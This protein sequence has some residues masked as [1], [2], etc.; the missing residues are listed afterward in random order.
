MLKHLESICVYPASFSPQRNRSNMDER[1]KRLALE[2]RAFMSFRKE[3]S[4]PEEV[5]GDQGTVRNN[6]GQVLQLKLQ[7]RRTKEA[8]MSCGIMPPLKSSA[9]FPEQRRSLE[10]AKNEH[11]NKRKNRSG[12]ES[13]EAIRKHILD[14]KST[15]IPL[16]GKQ[17]QQR[18]VRHADE[19]SN[20]I[21]QRPG[22]MELI[23][24]NILPVNSYFKQ[25]ITER[26]FPHTSR[27][28]SSCDE[29]SNDS[30]S[31]R[32]SESRGH[33][34]AI[35]PACS[36]AEKMAGN[37]LSSPAKV[38]PS[39]L[40]FQLSAIPLNSSMQ[41][42]CGNTQAQQKLIP[43]HLT[44]KQKKTKDN[45]PKIKKL[46]YHQYIPPDKKGETETL[47][48]LDSSYAKILQQQQIFLQLQ[49]LSQQQHHTLLSTEPNR[50]QDPPPSSSS[51]LPSNSSSAQLSSAPSTVTSIQHIHSCPS[52]AYLGG[53]KVLSLHLDLDE[54]KVAE[55]K[56]ELKLRRLPVSGTRKDLIERLRKYQKLSRGRRTT[57][58]PTAG[59]IRE[60][61]LE[62]AP[63]SLKTG[64]SFSASETS[65]QQLLRCDGTIKP[66]TRPSMLN[67]A[68]PEEISFNS[69]PLGELMSSSL[70]NLSL[71]PFTEA[72]FPATI[73]Q[74]P[75]CSSPTPCH[76]HLKSASLQTHSLVSSDAPATT[77]AAPPVTTDKDRMLQEKDKQ[78]AKLTRMLWHNQ[79]LVEELKMQLKNSNREVPEG[80]I[81][82]KVKE[83]PP[84]KQNEAFST[85]LPP[86]DPNISII[87]HEKEA[88][89]VTIKE[90]AMETEIAAE[91]LVQSPDMLQK[92]STKSQQ[93]Q[94]QINLKLRPKQGTFQRQVCL[95]DSARQ[96]AQQHTLN[97]LL[98]MQQQ[99]TKKQQHMVQSHDKVQETQQHL[100]PQK[101]SQKLQL[102]IQMSRNGESHPA[103]LQ[104]TQLK[105][106][107][108][109][110]KP[111]RVEEQQFER[112]Y[113]E[114]KRLQPI[115]DPLKN[116]CS[117]AL[118]SDSK[119]KHIQIPLT[120]HISGDQGSHSEGKASN[121]TLLQNEAHQESVEQPLQEAISS[122]LQWKKSSSPFYQT[123]MFPGL[124]VLLSPLS[125]DSLQAAA[126]QSPDKPKN[127]EDFI[128]I[129]L[130]DGEAPNTLK[131]SQ[132][133]FASSS[134]PS[135]LQLPLSPPNSPSSDTQQPG[136]PQQHEP[137]TPAKTTDHK[138]HLGLS[139]NAQLEDFLES[140]TGKSLLGVE[141]GGLLTLIDDLH[142][143]MLYTASI[144]DIP[145]APMSSLDKAS[146]SGQRLDSK[147]WLS[148]TTQ[149][150]SE[151]ESQTLTPLVPQIPPSVFSGEFIDSSDLHIDW[152]S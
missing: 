146:D 57:S 3:E 55:L 143:Q 131:V 6:C 111:K 61:E 24:K 59:G 129:I 74:E 128:D 100:H 117:L 68:I 126:W 87:S 43:D 133:S 62:R 12:S 113:K 121:H 66:L 21:A 42:T 11:C 147:G 81:L 45:K 79:R 145:S 104:Q 16:Q 109:L 90:E 105:T 4:G 93:T 1:A 22:P 138:L 58:S 95:Q 53:T 75:Q 67:G 56:C 83:E 8:L 149:G 118:V 47:P 40:P 80:Q 50:D 135:P 78:I 27:V 34:V 132:D 150:E 51:N 72:S 7:Q 20:R 18:K 89:K 49:I 137:W 102:Q 30:L 65:P 33:L 69:D 141:P 76:F 15:K 108:L 26:R 91:I 92:S 139:G 25:P 31:P 70:T 44:Q 23:H 82:R 148:F 37:N 54:M 9:A 88:T 142:S 94:D 52:S 120:N 112:C 97:R 85:S 123:E 38:P 122:G 124:D 151:W 140:N 98:L 5:S 41:R 71:Q 107:V 144:L 116:N 60:P 127:N 103:Q 136:S 48:N 77:A 152:D 63:A 125:P 84:E 10:R 130:Q 114:T 106:E 29:D 110:R 96:M 99:N 14:E 101:K 13:P 73:K 134:S 19:L 28:D 119:S 64:G 17:L 36:S 86:F 39:A 2:R 32:Q 46:K 115:Q 35:E